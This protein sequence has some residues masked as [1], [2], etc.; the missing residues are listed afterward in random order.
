MSPGR[1]FKKIKLFLAE[2]SLFLTIKAV[3]KDIKPEKKIADKD[4]RDDFRVSDPSPIFLF[5]KSEAM[6]GF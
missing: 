6:Q 1:F 3:H 5:S 2:I 4:R